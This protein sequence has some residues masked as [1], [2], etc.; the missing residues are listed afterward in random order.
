MHTGSCDGLPPM[1]LLFPVQFP[2]MHIAIYSSYMGHGS[3]KMCMLHPQPLAAHALISDVCE[4][5][6]RKHITCIKV[7]CT[8]SVHYILSL[9]QVH[10][11]SLIYKAEIVCLSV[12]VFAITRARFLLRRRQTRCSCWGYR[13]QVITGLSSPVLRFTESYPSI[14]GFF[15]AD[16]SESLSNGAQANCSTSNG[17]SQSVSYGLIT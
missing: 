11:V 5:P 6:Q 16:D 2:C 4:V 8:S 14:S 15:F 13:G 7:H 3:N 10:S 1:L 17:T 9:I 12:C